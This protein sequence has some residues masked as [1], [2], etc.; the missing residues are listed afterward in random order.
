M[1]AG[2]AWTYQLSF[3]HENN[4]SINQIC[5]HK[6]NNIF[7]RNAGTSNIIKQ[8]VLNLEKYLLH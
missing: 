3:Y 7:L 4:I 2:V 1:I 5:E 8:Q 6:I